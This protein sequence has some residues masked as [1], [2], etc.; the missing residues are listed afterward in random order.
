MS[1]I[2]NL[3]RRL[4][5]DVNSFARHTSFAHAFMREF[6]LY[7][8]VVLLAILLLVAYFRARKGDDPK[9]TVDTV[10][11]AG[12]GTLI[13]LGLNQP[14]SHL[15]GRVRPYNAIRGVEVLVPR[16]ND[17]TFP[18]DHATV[19]G[20][21]IVGLLLADLPTGLVATALGLFLA[22]ARVYV[23]AHYPGDVIGGL[24][25]GGLIVI[26][27]RPIGMAIISRITDLIARSPLK[28]L[29]FHKTKAPDSGVG[30]AA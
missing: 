16:A 5:L 27:L 6:A 15:V 29:I 21:V 28:I 9:K 24:I 7:G 23:G 22:F 26:V 20:A 3:D 17:F 10:L 19:A 8:G 12:A 2:T 25:F 18:S 14:L 4:Y 1:S 11:W 30:T 13:A